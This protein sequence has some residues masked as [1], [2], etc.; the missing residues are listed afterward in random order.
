[1]VRGI[2]SDQIERRSGLRT[3]RGMAKD[4]RVTFRRCAVY[5]FAKGRQSRNPVAHVTNRQIFAPHDA[6]DKFGRAR[7]IVHCVRMGR[8]LKPFH[9]YDRCVAL[10]AQYGDLA[11]INVI[12]PLH[13]RRCFDRCATAARM[14]TA[15][16]ATLTLGLALPTRAFRSLI[17]PP[18]DTNR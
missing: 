8:A 17:C 15:H 6:L 7:P 5:A 3:P 11:W 16:G 12:A 13:L 10:L 18:P 4:T 9:G 1:M 2:S 14:T